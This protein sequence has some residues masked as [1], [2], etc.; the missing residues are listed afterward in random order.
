MISSPQDV[1]VDGRPGLEITSQGAD[2]AYAD[3]EI[4]VAGNDMYMIVTGCYP[5]R[6]S[7]DTATFFASFHLD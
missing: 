1:T 3:G 5:A 6:A 2:G 4:L 7:V